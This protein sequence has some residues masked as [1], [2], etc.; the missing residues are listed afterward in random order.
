MS[1]LPRSCDPDWQAATARRANQEPSPPRIPLLVGAD[2]IGSVAPSLIQHLSVHGL[3]LDALGLHT[4]EPARSAPFHL[5]GSPTT[6]LERLARVLNDSGLVRTWHNEQL[7]LFNESGERLGAVERG[8]TRLLGIPVHC[9]HLVGIVEGH[10]VWVQQRS[11]QKSEDPGLWDTLMGG[12]IA[13]GE[14]P[15]TTL[16]R[17]LWEEAGLRTSD[18]EHLEPIGTIRTSHPA[19]EDEFSY[20]I[21]LIDCRVASLPAT[22]TPS[23]EDGEVIQFELLE[24]DA[25]RERLELD[26]F[27]L[28]AA[29]VLLHAQNS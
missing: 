6:A 13:F 8:V 9:I 15:E 2:Q 11:L 18:L 17:E 4:H 29:C 23:N 5:E 16:S 28:N 27:T 10:G 21:D 14:S 26:L 12:T 20:H 3:T 24:P 25:L 1:I 22:L 7:P 19:S